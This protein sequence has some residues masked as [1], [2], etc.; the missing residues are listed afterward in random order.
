MTPEQAQALR[1]PFPRESIGV[2]PK[3]Y[4]KES[5]KGNCNQC[6]GYHGMPAAHLD[7]VGHA[8]ATDRL[9]QVD[10]EWSWEPMA[11]DQFGLP[12]LDQRG[13]LWIR[14][15][16]A[17]VTR[18]GV[19]DGT[20]TKELIGDAIRN[21]AMRFGV[22][23][24]LWSKEDLHGFQTEQGNDSMSQAEAELANAQAAVRSAWEEHRGAWDFDAVG[25]EYAAAFRGQHIGQA[26]AV[27]LL[28]F[29]D[30]VRQPRPAPAI[31]GRVVHTDPWAKDA[32]DQRQLVRESV[33]A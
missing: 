28:A 2:L 24:D 13:Q 8:A 14:L 29:A 6:G 21:A 11:T 32:A 17:G 18:I 26:D 9:L 27:T 31:E 16:V 20:S 5:P 30:L 4:K 3:P 19:G 25:A 10:P 12:M 7:Y 1:A 22:A 33:N 15:T 23:L